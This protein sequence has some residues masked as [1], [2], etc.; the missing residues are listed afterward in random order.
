LQAAFDV[1]EISDPSD[2]VRQ[3]GTET[4]MV[5]VLSAARVA[6]LASAL[7]R[8][9]ALADAVAA[10]VGLVDET[11]EILWMNQTLAAHDP[12]TMRRYADGCV[13]ALREFN[14]AR[15]SDAVGAPSVRRLVYQLGTIWYEQAVAAVVPDGGAERVRQVIG[16]LWDGTAARRLQDRVEAVDAAGEELLRIDADAIVSMNMAERLRMLERRIVQI[17]HEVLHYEAFEVRLLD[18]STGK[19]ELVMTVGIRPLRIGVSLFASAQGNGVTGIVATTGRSYICRDARSDPNYAEGLE[20][21]ASALTVPLLLHD[22]V[23]GTLNIESTVP[24]RFDDEDRLLAE[25]FGRY[26]A[27]A[28]NILDLLVRE[29]TSTN[30]Q[31]S[32]AVVRELRQPMDE[33]ATLATQL[34]DR[35]AADGAA[36]GLVDRI[37]DALAAMRARLATCTA[38]PRTVLGADEMLAAASGPPMLQG[39]RIVVADDEP[40][41]RQTI[42]AV[43]V[44]RGA[45]VAMFSDGAGAIDEVR[46][47]A[48]EGKPCDLV[49]SDVRMP[50][51]NGYEV[52]RA[53][54]EISPDTPVILMTGFGYDPNH[55]IVRS[56]QEGLHCF[57]FKPFQVN[58]LLEEVEK[59][60]LTRS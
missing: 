45:E 19:L 7:P 59:A 46:R 56:S 57:L 38:G 6:A 42:R 33:I 60:L 10:G 24:S 28:L 3:A 22:R 31:V 53:T 20:N 40:A 37:G 34:R 52:F 2:A 9:S 12:E 8:A 43:L 44:Q 26:V 48:S 17:M 55:S 29:R 49:I 27:M 35:V 15:G 41:I 50:D 13:Q 36:A 30:E 51:R 18:R 23:V 11:G 21:A 1:H 58:Q 39:R 5:A 32:S 25:L 16:L 4:P 47:A 54:K 14:A